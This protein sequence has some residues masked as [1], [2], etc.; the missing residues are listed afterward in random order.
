MMLVIV[1]M[2]MMGGLLRNDTATQCGKAAEGANTMYIKYDN[3][4]T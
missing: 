3:A 1:M 2:I 4:A